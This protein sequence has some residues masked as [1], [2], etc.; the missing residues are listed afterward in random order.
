MLRC[1]RSVQGYKYVDRQRGEGDEERGVYVAEIF[2]DH[3]HFAIE[4][5][6]IAEH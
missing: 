5:D 6:F 2:R 1:R 4:S 3:L